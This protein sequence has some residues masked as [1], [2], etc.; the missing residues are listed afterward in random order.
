[1]T[2][3]AP[4]A[5]IASGGPAPA[6][7]AASAPYTNIRPRKGAF[8]AGEAAGTHLERRVCSWPTFRICNL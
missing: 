1:M 8:G 3:G 2:P 6:V 4:A 5:A 7:G